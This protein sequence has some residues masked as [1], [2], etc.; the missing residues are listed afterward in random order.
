MMHPLAGMAIVLCALGGLLGGLALYRRAADPHPELLRKLLHVGMGLVTL[1]FPYLFDRAWPVLTLGALSVA[2]L[3]CLRA[4]PALKGV[5]KVVSGVTRSSLGDVYFPLAVGVLWLLYL[6]ADE[7]E[8]GRRLIGYL[9]PL[10]LL[11]LADALAAL[12]GVGYGRLQYSTPDGV[13]SFEGS[14]AFFL[15]AFLCVH[16]PLLLLTDR[17]RAETLLI[18]VLLAWL[19]TMF[20]AITWGGL[21][22]LILPPV[23]HLLLVIHWDL[24]VGVL[25]GYIAEAAVLSAAAV[26]LSRRTP[27]RGSAVL[28]TALFGYTFWGLGG[29]PWLLPP[30]LLFVSLVVLSFRYPAAKDRELNVY[31]VVAVVAVGL[32]WLGLARVLD[33][34]DWLY[35]AAVSFAAHLGMVAVARLRLANSTAP[36]W[37]LLAVGSGAGWLIVVTGYAAVQ[38]GT[39]AAIREAGWAVPMVAL[40]VVGFYFTQPGM[41]DCPSD[42][43]RW[44]RQTVWAAVASVSAALLLAM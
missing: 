19:A 2:L 22:N 31:P 37:L 3:F 38:N 33:R 40:A 41:D 29:W 27:L 25:L 16:V 34:P 14:F 44:V 42:T 20:E 5:G 35:P 43:P 23:A 4:V 11:T 36:A 21:D 18:A 6:N 26:A 17:G 15:C 30:L 9:V 13:K 8:S 32:V 39:P 24:P 12:V 28:G 1:S 10:L 7:G